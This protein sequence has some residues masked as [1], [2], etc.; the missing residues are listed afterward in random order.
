LQEAIDTELKLMQVVGRK[1][2][3]TPFTV[4][5]REM[6]IRRAKLFRF[7]GAREMIQR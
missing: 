1:K 3:K 5:L 6:L 7:L 2:V 4:L